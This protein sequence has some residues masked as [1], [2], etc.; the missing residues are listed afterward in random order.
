MA[1]YSDNSGKTKKVD[2]GYT[3]SLWKSE[4]ERARKQMREWETHCEKI[5]KRYRD[6]RNAYD[7][8]TP[9]FAVLWSN[10][11]TL[12][13][14]LY[15]NPPEPVVQ[16][17]YLDKDPIGRV[18][19]QVLERGLKYEIESGH[20][21]KAMQ[22]VITDYCL[23]GRG[24][25]WVRYEPVF[26]TEPI[27]G[28]N[29]LPVTGDDG[30]PL[31]VEKIE[32]ESIPVDYVQWKDFRHGPARIWAEV[33]WIAKRVYLGRDKLVEL[34][35]SKIGKAVPLNFGPD[36]KKSEGGAD[37][38]YTELMRAEVWEIWCKDT[39]RV[40]WICGDYSDGPLK[41][42]DDPL[43]LEGFFPCP[44]PLYSTRTTDSLVPVPDYRQYQ[45]QAIE[46]DEL[47]TRID[48]L[49]SACKVVGTYDGSQAVLGNI[50]TAGVENDLIANDNWAAF[51][52]QGGLKGS[53]DFIPIE[54]FANVINVLMQARATTK[55]DIYEITGLADIIRGGSD[56]NETA[57]AQKI[58]GQFA[59]MRL[60]DRQQEVQRFIRDILRIQAEILC[61]HFQ[62]E[63]LWTMSGAA[64]MTEAEP[65]PAPPPQPGMPP[66]PQAPINPQFQQ[67]FQ[68]ALQL[69]KDDRL[70]GFRVDI[71]TDSTIAADQHADQQGRIQFVESIGSLLGQALPAVQQFPALGPLL[72][73]TL[74]FTVRGFHVGTDLES[75]FESAVDQLE[76]GGIPQKPDPQHMKAQLEQQRATH[77]AQIDQTRAQNDLQISQQKHQMDMQRMQMEMQIKQLE[78][79]VRMMEAGITAQGDP[80]N[81][82][83]VSADEARAQEL[84]AAIA[85]LAQAV[86][87]LGSAQQAPKR[88]VRD[89][90]GQV[91]HTETLQ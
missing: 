91:S 74:L 37:T 84:N 71:E 75:A 52:Q 69:L 72:G 40:H 17:R 65:P 55:N 47:T 63:S 5:V 30:E 49:V 12:L 53:L 23:V 22:G 78:T 70:R 68:Q 9:R 7:E 79:K 19:T 26:E 48:K 1:Q 82:Q 76:R 43:G 86:G 77:Q 33:P 10:V 66:Q 45:G 34:A 56:P 15:A 44:E 80:N 62:P 59:S 54:Q 87:A 36:G 57:T 90:N 51:A 60:K 16:R 64:Q 3:V 20:L 14:A 46:M 83:F 41:E 42:L 61:E 39:R 38:Q 25:A 2:P 88:V 29:G 8:Q 81:P 13:P 18:A 85:Q 58:K 28:A 24:Q 89:Q 32:R 67:I 50:F 35:G 4:L 73:K 21:H 31:S 6:E 11:Q 27:M